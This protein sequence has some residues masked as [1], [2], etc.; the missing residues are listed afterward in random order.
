MV[1][2]DNDIYIFF[3][4]CFHRDFGRFRKNR[5]LPVDISLSDLTVT[6]KSLILDTKNGVFFKCTVMDITL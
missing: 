4:R 5:N 6:K 3:K 2:S 1:R